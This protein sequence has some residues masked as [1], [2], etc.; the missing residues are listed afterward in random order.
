MKFPNFQCS[1]NLNSQEQECRT[2]N[3]TWRHT[4]KQQARHWKLD[5]NGVAE[6][7]EYK[8]IGVVKNYARPDI[9]EASEKLERGQECFQIVVLV[10]ENYPTIW[11]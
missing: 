6:L 1:A 11:S 2:N 5:G 10:A 4:G 3:I 7:D 8:S 9:S